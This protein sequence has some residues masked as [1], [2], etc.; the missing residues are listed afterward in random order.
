MGKG[1]YIRYIQKECQLTNRLEGGSLRLKPSELVLTTI[2]PPAKPQY[3]DNDPRVKVGMGSIAAFAALEF[4]WGFSVCLLYMP[5]IAA[6]L[7]SISGINE[8]YRYPCCLSLVGNKPPQFIKRP[9]RKRSTLLFSNLFTFSLPDP[10]EIFHGYA[11]VGA[12]SIGYNFFAH[13]TVFPL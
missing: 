8:H 9:T 13:D 12:F 4:G 1:G 10:F 11:T 7:R 2:G 3:F 6:T 5:A